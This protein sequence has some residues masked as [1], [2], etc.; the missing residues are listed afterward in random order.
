MEANM[1]RQRCIA[2]MVLFLGLAGCGGDG[3][4]RVPVH[5]KLTARGIALGNAT[6]QFIPMD[7]TKGEGGI[8]KSEDDGSFI[9]IGSRAGQKAI[10][11]GKYKVRVSRMLARDGSA[12]PADA[13]QA[14]YPDA[15]ESVPAPYSSIDSPLEA[16]VPQEG[17]SVNIDIPVAVARPK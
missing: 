17:G 13:K 12:L 10:V 14:D 7:S 6:I 4:T 11:P 9:L 2:A 15:K 8:A 16:S 5:G 3:L 1:G